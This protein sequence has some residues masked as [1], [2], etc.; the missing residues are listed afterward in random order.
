MKTAILN[1]QTGAV[2]HE[3]DAPEGTPPERALG[4]AAEDAVQNGVSLAFADLRDADLSEILLP[5]ADMRYA[6]I[7][8]SRLSAAGVWDSDLTGAKAVDVMADFCSLQRSILVDVDFTNAD[9]SDSLMEFANCRGTIFN[10]AS[11]FRAEM[12]CTDLADVE[13]SN[14]IMPSGLRAEPDACASAPH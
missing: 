12:S 3:F 7:S 8:R 14:T 2:I 10:N 6:D 1:W 11:L 4:L 5:G 13:F 9:L